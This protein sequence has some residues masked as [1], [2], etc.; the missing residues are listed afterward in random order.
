MARF[1]YLEPHSLDEALQ[2]LA[3]RGDQARLV[4][5]STDF[6]VRWRT[7]VWRPESVV[8][9]QHVPGLD[10]IR[11]N[12]DDGLAIGAMATVQDIEQNADV[13]RHYP[14]LAAGATAFAGVQVRNLATVAGNVCNASPAGD[15][16]PAL[17][18]CNA[19]CLIV[20]S[21]G[22]RW[23]PL[24]ELFVGPGQT[25]LNPGEI[26][27]ELRL[28]TPA[29]NT[30]GLYVKH[31][32]RGAMDI[33]AVGAASVVSLSDDGSCSSVR[34]AL[35]AV[36]PTPIRA[37]GAEGRL[38]GQQPTAANLA[39]AA[40][41]S[42]QSCNPIADVRSGADYRREIARVLTE[43]TLRHAVATAGNAPDFADIRRLAVQTAW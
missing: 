6:L 1:D 7:G 21:T 17:L 38:V 26:L 11:W 42:A 32:P 24:D 28:P 3:D 36:A 23:L 15:T 5:G 41:L 33:S 10:Y 27:S 18:A 16:L 37:Y 9:M 13:R 22:Q 2:M 40:R 4:A 12:P 19:Q 29:P 39:E 20:S 14:A 35:G 34:I 8:C 25:A 43:R 31:S 30:G